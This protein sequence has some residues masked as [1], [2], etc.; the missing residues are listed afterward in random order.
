MS[1]K[2]KAKGFTLVELVVVVVIIGILAAVAAPRF[3]SKADAAKAQVALQKAA[4]MRSALEVFRAE[5]ADGK[6]PADEAGVKTA[7]QTLMRG[8]TPTLQYKKLT[9]SA[10]HV[11][12]E[13]SDPTKLP[14][15]G[16]DATTPWI[17]NSCTG[18]VWVNDSDL[19]DGTFTGP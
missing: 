17:Y 7:L 10:I 19:F 18:S 12:N 3:F 2:N 11:I 5:S 16:I 9:G 4:A 15:T 8:G 13:T 14:T 1:A 6:F